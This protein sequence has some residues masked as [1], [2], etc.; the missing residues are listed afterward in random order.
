MGLYIVLEINLH[1][2][3]KLAGYQLADIRP[4]KN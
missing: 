4:K 1:P 2:G 3:E